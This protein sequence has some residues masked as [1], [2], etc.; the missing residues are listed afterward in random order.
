MHPKTDWLWPLRK[1]ASE[2][3]SATLEILAMEDMLKSL[4]I[5]GHKL[6]WSDDK[7]RFPLRFIAIIQ[8]K[9]GDSMG[10]QLEQSDLVSFKELLGANSIQVDTAV[11]LEIEKG[12][13]AEQ[14][15]FTKLWKRF[16]LSIKD[17]NDRDENNLALIDA[18]IIDILNDLTLEGGWALPIWM[19]V[20]FK[21]FSW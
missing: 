1:Q 11:Q 10:N 19:R 12:F 8:P 14:E 9:L 18:L 15:F 4:I 5:G 21:H 2:L 17:M 7:D 3:R 20:N 16:K 13:F 6:L